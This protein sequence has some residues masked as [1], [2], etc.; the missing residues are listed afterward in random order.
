MIFKISYENHLPVL[1]RT[2]IFNWIHYVKCVRIRS[3]S[4][5]YFPA[6][7]LNT[8]RYSVF[9]HIQSECGKNRPE[10]LRIR[11]LFTQ[12]PVCTNIPFLFNVFHYS[13]AITSCDWLWFLLFHTCPDP[14]NIYLFKVN[15]RNTRKR[16]E[17]CSKL[18]IKT[19]ERRQWR[20][21]GVFIAIWFYCYSYW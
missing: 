11:T 19:P 9:P 4:G 3:F 15:N 8:E 13:I 1:Q 20:R 16:C 2:W 18:T 21:S 14:A 6:F 10:K 12:C 7:R 17:T 5:Q